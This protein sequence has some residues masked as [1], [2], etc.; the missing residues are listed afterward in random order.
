MTFAHADS[1]GSREILV[2]T[3]MPF[4]QLEMIG[5]AIAEAGLRLRRLDV[6]EPAAARPSSGEVAGVISLGGQQSLL[7]LER[8]PFLEWEIDFIRDAVR[9]RTPVLGLCLGA[10]LLTLATGGRVERLSEP[11]VAWQLLRWEA[12]GSDDPL[13][14]GLGP[15]VNVLEWHND[16]VVLG[17]DAVRLAQ[18]PVP[19][20]S[21]FRSGPSGWG[22]QMHLEMG[23]E[24]LGA[25][26][27]D[28]IECANITAAG[29]TI[30][31][32]R[33]EALR[34]LPRQMDLGQAILERFVA[35]VARRAALEPV[36][37]R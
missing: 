5:P 6:R 2:I 18:T 8:E 16:A 12:A 13:L 35:I 10:Q 32:F 11:V 22:S 33:E 15:E 21:V 27:D 4:P 24:M 26:L 31:G 14:G 25:L 23:P 7:A 19:A 1:D 36:V 20:C 28:P 17:P 29:H 30:D 9:N 37:G 3:H 34:R